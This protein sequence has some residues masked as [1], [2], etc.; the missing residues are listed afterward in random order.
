[1]VAKLEQTCYDILQELDL[2]SPR[3]VLDAKPLIGGV[4]SDIFRVETSMRTYC[5]KF[6]IEK[7]RV[8]ADWFAPLH[9]NAAEYEWLE[10]VGE[11]FPENVPRLYG[12]SES[13]HGFV[14]ECISGRCIR[15]WKNDLL[16][17]GPR[18]GD[19]SAVGRLL[20]GIHA[21]SVPL[22]ARGHRFQNQTDFYDLRTEP[23][24][25]SLQ[26]K[27]PDIAG[28]IDDIIRA[29]TDHP[30][31]LVHGDIS[32]KNILFRSGVPIILD[33]ECATIGDPCFD[34]A[35][36]LNHL[37]LKAVHLPEYSQALLKEAVHLWG[38]YEKTIDWETPSDLEAR[39][40]ALLPLLFLARVDGKSP[41]EYLSSENR[42]RV[43]SLALETVRARPDT[44]RL[45]TD[46]LEPALT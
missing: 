15:Q 8:E 40:C 31:A 32:P 29:M 11:W 1:M 36:C 27:H 16:A 39:V 25:V 14:M 22:A 26:S 19:A 35:F 28:Q 17:I 38:A 13:K 7:L 2:A 24:L 4:A 18:S 34:V 21:E 43:R 45:L 23:Y 42:D 41:V 20:G 10:A 5:I 6:A 46:Q 33:A 44:I 3:D 9:R 12:R 37:L 30:L